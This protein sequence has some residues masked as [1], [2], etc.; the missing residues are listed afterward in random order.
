MC[1]LMWRIHSNRAT[2]RATKLAM[3]LFT[4]F[5]KEPKHSVSFIGSAW[6]KWLTRGS[7]VLCAW[8]ALRAMSKPCAKASAMGSSWGGG[9]NI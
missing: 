7:T 6:C 8:F 1:L 2:S 4:V 5:F 9:A 3:L